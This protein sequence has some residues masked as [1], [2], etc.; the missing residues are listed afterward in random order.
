MFINRFYQHYF[1]AR[2]KKTCEWSAM[3]QAKLFFLGFYA[4]ASWGPQLGVE[5]RKIDPF[6]V[7][8]SFYI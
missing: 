8:A 1:L 4:R 6:N 7:Y 2:V 5:N 3:K